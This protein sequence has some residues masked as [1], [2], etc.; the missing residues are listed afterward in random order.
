MQS[1]VKL[2]GYFQS[3][4]YFSTF[5]D[6]I[7]KMLDI[8][9]QKLKVLSKYSHYF[10]NNECEKY[11]S[12]H[13][14]LSDYK[15]IQH[16]YPILK[17]QYYEKAL[18]YIMAETE[19]KDW[20][21]LYFCEEESNKE[22]EETIEYLK[23]RCSN[24]QFIKVPDD[25]SD[26]EQMLIMSTCLHNII[27]NSTF[28]WWGAY[29]NTNQDKIVCFPNEWFGPGSP[30]RKTVYVNDDLFPSTWMMIE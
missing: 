2:F 14:R 20:K 4:K 21:I 28:S 18:L 9:N 27:A 22:V 25:I 30:N 12:V 7:C 15:K 3:H 1:G 6:T 11:I 17:K 29:L 10:E 8:E 19:K 24:C 23:K 5:F 26:W 13:F 16:I